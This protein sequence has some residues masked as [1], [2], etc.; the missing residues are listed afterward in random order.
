MADFLVKNARL[1]DAAGP[2]DIDIRAGR[3][4]RIGVGLEA[5]TPTFDAEGGLLVPGFCESHIHLDKACIL[6]RCKGDGTLKGA[7][8]SVSTAKAAFTEEDVYARG[9]RVIERAIPQGTNAM[10]THVEID[11][12]IGLTGFEAVKRLR[13]SYAFAL[14]LQ[15]CV[16]PQEG[17]TNLPGTEELLRQALEEGADLL[18]GC[19]YTDT[20]PAEQIRRLFAMAREFDVDLDF[21][22]DF[23]LDIS[24]RHLDEVARQTIANNWQNRV[25]IGHVTK[26]SMLPKA[27]LAETAALLKDAGIG[28]TVLPATDLFLTGRDADHA[29]PRGVAPAHVL[30]RQGIACTIATNNVLNPFTPFGDCSLPRLANLYANIAHLGTMDDMEM[31]FA[32]ISDTPGRMVGRASEIAVGGPGTFI[33]LPTHSRGQAVAEIVRPTWG[34]KDG[35]VVF[36]QPAAQL[37]RP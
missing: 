8:S 15:I 32:M 6:E 23:D 34:M 37:F 18:G 14:D 5:D 24:W 3:I 9:A 31:C 7:I 22:L 27:E 16:F 2:V 19:P 12:V 35:R 30:A 21:H 17:L 10:R 13:D 11:P 26:L 4:V 20:D 29:I 33:L 28:L 25:T 36:S 1:A